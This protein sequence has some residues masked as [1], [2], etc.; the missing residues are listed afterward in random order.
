MPTVNVAKA[1]NNVDL[2]VREWSSSELSSMI[3]TGCNGI[4]TWHGFCIFSCED[5]KKEEENMNSA[6]RQRLG[7]VTELRQP[8][9]GKQLSPQR[10]YLLEKSLDR[11][12]YFKKSG[13]PNILVDAEKDL[14]RRRLL[15]LCGI[16]TK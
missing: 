8:G 13:A 9:F 6:L 16:L 11:Y 1:A 2:G 15:S 14:I 7:N 3:L 5:I 10:F 12:E 4:S